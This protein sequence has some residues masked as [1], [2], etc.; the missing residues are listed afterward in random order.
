MANPICL[1]ANLWQS[2]KLKLCCSCLSS[3][4]ISFHKNFNFLSP[5]KK[6][7][8]SL[9]I[10]WGPSQNVKPK[11]SKTGW[12]WSKTKIRP[13]TRW[14]CLAA[15]WQM[16]LKEI[17]CNVML[18]ELL[19]WNIWSGKVIHV[20]AWAEMIALTFWISHSIRNKYYT[21]FFQVQEL[22]KS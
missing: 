1:L 12:T 4:I 14:K 8:P 3:S 6:S 10:V 9:N 17:V 5:S 7:N 19:D 15:L 13:I 18:L 11:P 20:I 21:R 22:G 2:G 16:V